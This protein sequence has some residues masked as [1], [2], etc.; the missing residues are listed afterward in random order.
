[1]PFI[2][3]HIRTIKSSEQILS[4][5]HPVKMAI[6]TCYFFQQKLKLGFFSY[7]PEALN[8]KTEVVLSLL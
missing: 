8:I 6:H 7:G 3:E 4:L 5:S 2:L 1:M